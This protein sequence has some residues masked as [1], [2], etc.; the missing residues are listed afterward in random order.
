MGR[1]QLMDVFIG[2]KSVLFGIYLQVDFPLL[3]DLVS[4]VGPVSNEHKDCLLQV[5]DVRKLLHPAQSSRGDVYNG[6]IFQNKPPVIQYFLG[7]WSDFFFGEHLA[8]Q[9]FYIQGHIF[10]AVV[11]EFQLS[12]Q[13]HV[14]DFVLRLSEK[15]WISAQHYEKHDSG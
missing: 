3:L 6:N 4:V 1:Q 2:H 12:L 10:P 13:D 9:L 15:W 14:L 5:D 8:Y 7:R 11:F